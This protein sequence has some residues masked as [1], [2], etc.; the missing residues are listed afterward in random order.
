MKQARRYAI[1]AYGMSHND[2]T[3]GNPEDTRLLEIN[4]LA[5][6]IDS[7][8]YLCK[9]MKNLPQVVIKS[10]EYFRYM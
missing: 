4:A 9:Y 6:E 1:A 5:I 2:V 7:T 3:K 10:F 8:F